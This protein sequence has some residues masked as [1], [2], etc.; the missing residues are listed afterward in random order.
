MRASLLSVL[1]CCSFIWIAYKTAA[2]IVSRKVLGIGTGNGYGIR[3][4]APNANEFWT[5]DKNYIT[6]DYRNYP[7]TRFVKAK[8]P[9]LTNIP[10]NYFD[11]VVCFQ[12]IEHVEDTLTLLKEIKRV[13]KKD[14]ELLISTPNKIRSL[15][16]NPYHVQ[17]YTRDEFKSLLQLF[18][19]SVSG[20]GVLGND[21]VELYYEKSKNSVNQILSF[22]I[23]KLNQRLP[24]W[25]LRLPYDLFNRISRHL[26]LIDNKELTM[27]ISDRDYYLDEPNDN[28]YDFLFVTNDNS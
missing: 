16:R 21:N 28:C 25:L 3:E 12:L 10:Y 22:D 7:N 5:L 18:F 13:L 9:P 11:Y 1:F 4:I 6:I 8:V 17:E 27:G 26:I 15:T 20:Y 19:L 14:G 23:L 2:G 24:R